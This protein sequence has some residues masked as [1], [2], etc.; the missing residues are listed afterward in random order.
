LNFPFR[1]LACAVIVATPL[2][3]SAQT[4]TTYVPPKLAARGATSIAP[5]GNGAVTVQVLVKKDGSF[6]VIKVI[7]SSNAAD[8]A[9]AL[10]IAKTSKYKPAVRNGAEVDAFYDFELNFGSGGAVSVSGGTA[11]AL[12]AIRAGNYADAKTQLTAY[13]ADHPSDTDAYTL[14]GVADAFSGDSAGAS[15]AF[16][17]AG[18][19]PDQYKPLA[20]QS[21]EKNAGALLEAKQYNDAIAAA[22]HAI[23]L[24]PQSLQGYYIRGVSNADLQNDAAAILDLQKARSIAASLNVDSKLQVT[25][26]FNL[27]QVQLDAG[28][29]GEAATTMKIVAAADGPRSA[30]LDK[31]AFVAVSNAAIELANAGKTADAVSRFESGAN[32]FPRSAAALYAQAAAVL[33]HAASADKKPDW[34][35]V[36]AEA[37]KALSLDANSGRAEFILGIV[38]ANQKDPKGAADYMNKA[39]ASADYTSDPGLAKQIDSALNQLNGTPTPVPEQLQGAKRSPG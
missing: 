9:A 37:E 26:A 6:Q 2:A 32:S 19:V 18:T 13:V 20:L 39:K 31:R 25:L 35:G 33:A 7:K 27:A 38:A 17:K 16:D 1:L 34:A 4:A 30:Q 22:N 11:P 28:Q 36:K 24:N 14:L 29:Y 8:N 10:E 23:S 15:A 21:Y 12:A 3:A 5:G